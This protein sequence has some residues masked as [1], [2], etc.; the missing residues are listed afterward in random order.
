MLNPRSVFR[1]P[2]VAPVQG[3]ASRGPA[4]AASATGGRV[5]V[6]TTDQGV[7]APAIEGPTGLAALKMNTQRQE[8]ATLLAVCRMK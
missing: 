3:L 2:P 6:I 4:A 5:P 8:Q 7:T 1:A